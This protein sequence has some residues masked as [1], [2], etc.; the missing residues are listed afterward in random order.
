MSEEAGSKCGSKKFLNCSTY[1]YALGSCG[2][3]GAEGEG[4][5]GGEIEIGEGGEGGES[6]IRSAL[7]VKLSIYNIARHCSE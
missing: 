4:G 5:V 1:E 2:G 3:D 6:V 7:I